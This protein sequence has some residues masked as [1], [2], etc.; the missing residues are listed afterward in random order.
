MC[1]TKNCLGGLDGTYIKVRVPAV[2]KQRYCSRKNDIATNVLG[3]CTPDMQFIYVL[4]GWEGS[5]AD[6]RVLR[7]AL[8]RTN[9][10]RFPRGCYYLVDAGYKNCDGFLAPYRGQC[11]HL[12][13]WGNPLTRKEELFNM[14]HSSARNVIERMFKLLKLRQGIIRNGSY[15]PIDTQ[16]A[17]I[18]ACCYLHNLIRQQMGSDPLE[19]EL[20][21]FLQQQGND[22]AQ[23]IVRTHQQSGLNLEMV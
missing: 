17:I 16:I 9:G 21:D 4:A 13:E 22:L 19:T 23:L 6:A 10:L 2:D 7:D 15:Y 20:E 8:T 5:A 18:L 3:A 14:K 1:S 12:K 11:Y